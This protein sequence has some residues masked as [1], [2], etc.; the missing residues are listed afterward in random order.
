MID[1]PKAL[2]P[3]TGPGDTGAVDESGTAAGGTAVGVAAGGS[4]FF[5]ILG[6]GAF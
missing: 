6:S 2:A 1:L 5:S 4:A 3:E